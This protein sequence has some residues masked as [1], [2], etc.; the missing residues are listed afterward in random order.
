MKYIQKSKKITEFEGF[1]VTKAK[2]FNQVSDRFQWL[3]Y[4]QEEKFLRD[5]KHTYKPHE[6]I[7][8]LPRCTP[9]FRIVNNAIILYYGSYYVTSVPLSWLPDCRQ[10]NFLQVFPTIH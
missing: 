8:S 3:P 7:H 5:F 4:T 9:R 6:N 1:T 10:H 2:V